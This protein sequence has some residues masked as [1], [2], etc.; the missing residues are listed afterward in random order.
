MGQS[1]KT[2]TFSSKEY[3]R[4]SLRLLENLQ[5]LKL[6]MQK[7]DFGVGKPSLGVELEVYL[8]N[9]HNL[10]AYRNMELW[11]QLKDPLL[12]LELNRYNLEYNFAPIEIRNKPFSALQQQICTTM[13]S[14][15]KSASE[16]ELRVL[17]IGILPS[18][19]GEDIGDHA[20]TDLPRFHALSRGL[21]SQREDGCFDIHIGGVDSLDLQAHTLTLEGANTSMQ[22]HYRV[23]PKEF[24][25]IYNAIQLVTPVMLALAANSPTFLGHR[26]WQETRIALFKQ[27]IDSRNNEHEWRQPARV[28][29][30]HGWLRRGA[31]DL[32]AEGVNLFPPLL[33]IVNEE[34][35][36]AILDKG[37]TPQL[38][39][40][41]LHQ[42]SIWQWN[43]PIY[44]PVDGGH[45]RIEMRALP[46]GPS[47]IDMAANTAFYIGLAEGLKTAINDL[48]PAMPFA[49]AERNFYKAAK[50]GMDAELIWPSDSGTGLNTKPVLEIAKQLLPLARQGLQNINVDDD[51]IETMLSIIEERIETKTNGA[52]W[53]LD[54]LDKLQEHCTLSESLSMLVDRYMQES[55]SGRPV[56][57]WGLQL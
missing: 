37:E 52:S 23:D 7:P 36:L 33:P 20:M 19:R 10:P 48:L 39:E 41:R 2:S 55:E 6:L 21:K 31:Y 40:L 9:Q 57:Q 51:E 38:H 1:I 43:R 54:M 56:A 16:E 24:A 17:A 11:K 34:D 3:Q 32:F 29:F 47:A 14:L 50:Y 22:I 26:L 30:G 53:Q 44:D 12:T 35:P 45:L 5:A 49:Y 8:I 15:Q 25:D 13:H 18:L 27:A 42:G 4:F 46:A 28:A